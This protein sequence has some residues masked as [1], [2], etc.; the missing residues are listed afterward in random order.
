MKK[1]IHVFL[2]ALVSLCL[3]SQGLFADKI[4]TRT[5]IQIGYSELHRDAKGNQI[6]AIYGTDINT[7]KDYRSYIYIQGS[8][9]VTTPVYE[10]RLERS[11]DLGHFEYQNVGL[12]TKDVSDRF[13]M[14]LQNQRD[15]FG[16]A[17]EGQT[18]KVVEPYPIEGDSKSE[19]PSS[20][21]ESRSGSS[22]S[23]SIGSGHLGPQYG[24]QV[25]QKLNDINWDLKSQ[26][27]V[28]R[29]QDEAI[30]R[31]RQL[32][33]EEL[34]QMLSQQGEKSSAI[35][36]QMILDLA[37]YLEKG[38]SQKSSSRLGPNVALDS[39]DLNPGGRA[40]LLNQA[41]QQ[42]A[43]GQW[44]QLA[45]NTTLLFNPW[46]GIS[47]NQETSSFADRSGIILGPVFKPNALKIAGDPLFQHRLR[48]TANRLQAFTQ[49]DST[50]RQSELLGS[51][52]FNAALAINVS[53]ISE[54]WGSSDR[55]EQLL[56]YAESAVDFLDGTYS[57]LKVGVI[58]T[59]TG[60]KHLAVF[61]GSVAKY[62]AQHPLE[63]GA[64]VVQ[65]FSDFAELATDPMAMADLSEALYEEVAR[66]APQLLQHAQGYVVKNI[67]NGSARQRG[68][69]VGRATWE[70]AQF[71]LAGEV[72][73]VAS[74]ST[75]ALR[76]VAVTEEVLAGATKT[77]RASAA[78]AQKVE[79]LSA[80]GKTTGSYVR[81]LPDLK[82]L[83][84]A[85]AREKGFT[86]ITEGIGQFNDFYLS[87]E[88]HI[89]SGNLNP[90][91]LLY[92]VQ[93]SAQNGPGVF[94]GVIRA[95][96]RVDAEALYN[97]AK[98]KNPAYELAV[99]VVKEPV[100][101]YAGS[102]AGGEGRQ[103]MLAT[104]R[105]FKGFPDIKLLIEEVPEARVKL[106]LRGSVE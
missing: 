7:N 26:E 8:E 91:D 74:K 71:A 49:E 32:A 43:R 31:E 68:Q 10:V 99:Y 98:W 27:M 54:M 100:T 102:V 66:S 45:H 84:L 20:T 92:Q 58:E 69:F 61:A 77:L 103:I 12:A 21:K 105:D 106:P 17:N 55:A 34:R 90:G 53:S 87:F 76:S 93:R 3:S 94:F 36:A 6:L 57:G 23:K 86:K 44:R 14:E 5:D 33:R 81:A 88:G 52:V 79:A 56:N 73:S 22:K 51:T 80:A 89:F 70:I 42:K 64:R 25:G 63:A 85:E 96:D 1:S 50:W 30:R 46:S 62:T 9:V 18:K 97:I 75:K 101:V 11:P 72:L 59:A 37:I 19:D 82:A 15:K 39:I 67:I 104:A 38:S 28:Q 2:L 40:R 4:Y 83:A 65:A 48:Q 41:K 47:R 95:V 78:I 24:F 13:N 16:G 35:K 60:L 29:A